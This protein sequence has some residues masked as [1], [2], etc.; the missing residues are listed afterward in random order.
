[1]K[2]KWM[3]FGKA[4]SIQLQDKTTAVHHLGGQLMVLINMEPAII[5]LLASS[6]LLDGG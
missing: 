2:N 5:G 1:M 6:G 3:H 4:L